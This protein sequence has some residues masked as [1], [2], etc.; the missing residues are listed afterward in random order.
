L[1]LAAV[2]GAA[3]YGVVLFVGYMQA[4]EMRHRLARLKHED[5][6]VRF[7]AAKRLGFGAARY[8]E[9]VVPALAETMNDE[10]ELV[11]Y[12]AAHSLALLARGR[13]DALEALTKALV[14]DNPSLRWRAARALG[15]APRSDELIELLLTRLEDSHPQVRQDAA[16]ALRWQKPRKWEHLPPMLKAMQR[17]DSKLRASIA[18]VLGEFGTEG[19]GVV[20]V[21]CDALM[22]KNRYVRS[23]AIDSLGKI[24][25]PARQAVP[26][27]LRLAGDAKEEWEREEAAQALKRIDPKAAE[28]AG[29]K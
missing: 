25:T 13:P 16:E 28:K 4:V 9:E 26:A 14:A 6:D 17:T 19:G 18:E 21:L 3:V 12:E 20:P 27:L 11:A 24:G 2:L 10:E 29:I 23:K 22:D 1:L 8:Y 15:H 7:L 5:P